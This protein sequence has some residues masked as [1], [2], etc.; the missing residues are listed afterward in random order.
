MK[1]LGLQ[2]NNYRN[3]IDNYIKPCEKV[4][5]IYGDNAQGKTNLLEIIWLLGGNSSFRGSKDNELINFNE[6]NAK[7][8]I[9]FLSQKR[10]Q[11]AQISYFLEPAFKKEIKIN[12]VYK[13]SP[14]SLL[15]KI[16]VVVFSPEHLSLVKD[17][18]M[19][20]RK[21][22]DNAITSQKTK[23]SNII[24]KYNKTL[25]Q[26][27][28]LLKDINKHKEL[29]ATLPIWDETL[30]RLGSYII[31]ERIKYIKKLNVYSTKYH[32]GISDNKEKLNIEYFS[33]TGINNKDNLKE[34]EKKLIIAT[35]RSRYS[36]LSTGVTSVGPHRDDIDLILNNIDA[37][38]FASQGQQRSIVLSLKLAEA[39]ILK[40]KT[41]EN[42]IIL[43]D[44]VL[45]ELDSKRQDFLL[46]KIDKYQVFIT[47][48][49][50]I[51]KKQIKDV[52]FF[53]V[54]NGK[55]TEEQQP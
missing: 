16:K 47:C 13:K 17:G 26:R 36:D 3:L 44:D 31:D 38:K 22:I 43:L 5:I 35:K 28:A 24:T 34:I 33:A 21:F 50:K 8:G 14:S 29:K 11:K 20:R 48:C 41:N 7:I 19:E 1:V 15:E 53:Y 32:L 54:K 49:E 18:P 4:N 10:E 23:I 37:K 42:P 2:F 25:S 52:S 51:N 46:N 9:N 30:C 39:A 55:I 12:G 40:E 45:S 6:K 27:N